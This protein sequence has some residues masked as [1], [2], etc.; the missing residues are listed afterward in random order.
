MLN[1]SAQRWQ[2]IFPKAPTAVLEAFASAANTLSVAGILESRTR[3]AYFCANVEHE[4]DGFTIP[5]LTEN[6]NYSAARMATVWPSRFKGPADV[7]NR[8]GAAP[9]WQLR[10]FDD[11]YGGRMGNRPGTSDGSRFIGRGGPQITGRD[12]YEAIGERI[13][14]AL[15][16]EPARASDLALQPAI[17]AAF[18]TWKGMNVFADRGDFTGC[19]KAWNGGTNGMAD[20]RVRMAGND[21]IIARLSIARD[22]VGTVNEI[23]GTSPLAALPLTGDVVGL[24]GALNKLGA[25]PELYADGIYGS[26]TRA[27]VRDF[28]RKRGLIVD[29]IAGPKT[30][31]AIAA[32]LKP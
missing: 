10:A 23:T 14:V 11:I 17:C 7:V 31:A 24:Q 12:G 9:G 30:L 3:L 16:L 22:A 25:F 21:P 2:Q 5:H 32:A 28:Q 18:W 1:V 27:A 26:M 20:R 8:Y 19:V 6:I 4:C 13:G 29:G 15:A